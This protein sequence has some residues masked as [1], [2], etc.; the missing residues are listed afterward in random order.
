MSIMPTVTIGGIAVPHLI[1]INI[2]RG[3]S[4]RYDKATIVI[5]NVNGG[6]TNSYSHFSSVLITNNSQ[7]LFSGRLLDTSP[8]LH[9]TLRILAEDKSAQL[10]DRE[11]NVSYLFPEPKSVNFVI[12]D[13]VYG[14]M[15]NYLPSVTLT[16]V[17]NVT[18]LIS[19]S[20]YRLSI[21]DV[22]I[23]LADISSTS[24]YDF[25]IDQNNDLHFFPA[26][27]VSSGLTIKNNGSLANVI[28]WEFPFEG[29]TIY[30]RITVY[31]NPDVPVAAQV[32]DLTSQSLYGIKE[33]PAIIDTTIN[34]NIEAKYLANRILIQHANPIQTGIF[35]V[36]ASIV[37]SLRPGQ[38]ITVNIIGSGVASTQYVVMEMTM[39]YPSNKVVI[40]TNEWYTSISDIIANIFKELRKT[41]IAS[42]SIGNLGIIIS[43]FGAVVP[44]SP[45]LKAVVA[46]NTG[47]FLVGTA[48]VGFSDCA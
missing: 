22:L 8:Y 2:V 38:L 32:N 26:G 25:Y 23:Y 6:K 14:I 39:S 35:T 44:A 34:T 11:V 43:S 15:P 29:T 5:S 33:M 10:A 21:L 41:S 30:N 42:I 13:S 46:Q 9:Q 40:R 17:Q 27:S 45:A 36:R 24:G 37:E 19:K 1:S 4:R 7:T 28:S 12:T 20:F 3:V 18:T 48:T 47:T 16:N 31:G